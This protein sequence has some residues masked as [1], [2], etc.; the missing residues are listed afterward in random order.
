M[1]RRVIDLNG[2]DWRFG[3]APSG[4]SP[5]H[6]T[7]DELEGVA[8]WMPARV[9]GNVR[10]D[11]MRAGRLPDLSVG[12]QA[13]DSH[14]VDHHSWW[15]QRE[16]PHLAPAGGRV[17]LVLRGIDYLS[18]L[19][20]NGHHLDR[21]EG[22]FS[23]QVHEISALLRP[24]NRLAIRIVGSQWLPATR[25]SPWV[26]LLNHVEARASSLSSRFPHRRDTLKCQM[27]FGWDFAP[28]LRT[29]GI[30]DDVYAIVS[31][32]PLIAETTVRSKVA[33]GRADLAID[34]ALNAS[35]DCVVQLRCTVVGETFE[36]R[37][38]SVEQPAD[39]VV[40]TNHHTISLSL[41]QPHLWW[42]WDH[43][44]PD[45]Y[46]LILEIW[47]GDQRL[48]SLV[49]LIGLR[50]VEM[51]GW[52]LRINGRRIYARGANWVPASVLPGCVA[53]DDYQALLSSA[54][55]ANMNFLRV[56]GGGLREKQVF[57]DLCDRMGI[58]LW[59]EFPLACAFL[60]RF[61]QSEEYLHLVE[62]EA[63]A[64]V[65][66]L[67]NHPSI[68]LWCGGNEFDPARNE[69]LVRTLQGV[70]AR[71]DPARPFLPASPAQGDSH[72]WRVWHNYHPPSAYCND[73]A[74][75]A[76]EFGLQAPPSVETLR[77]FIPPEE[78][79]P[80]GPSWSYHGAELDK[81]WRYARPFLPSG[82]I[83]LEAFVS[84]GQR[85]QAYALQIAIE[86]Y[87]RGKARG[88]GGVL[89]W[90]L[91]EPWPAISWALLD[92]FR[93]TKPAYHEVRRLLAP[94]LISLHYPLK[95]YKAG[96]VLSG[97]VWVVNDVYQ[98]LGSCQVEVILWDEAGQITE[99]SV[100][101]ADVAPDSA[102]PVGH[103]HWVLSP[104]SSWRLTCALLRGDQILASN[105]Y[106]LSVHDG[107]QPTRSQRLRAWL[108]SV[109][110]PS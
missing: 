5:A 70:M 12:T 106:D 92:Y 90:Q 37:P 41:A 81:L 10:A 44:C 59:Q 18:D 84:A 31:G 62:N 49:Q 30:W 69:P 20:L 2:D 94:L 104:G 28:A 35:A 6:T 95:R 93:C 68:V 55:Q 71:E 100:Q 98:A 74:L 23:P 91:N 48:D 11:L 77:H 34:V 57:Y 67:R 47:Q 19:F 42:P 83:D 8:D 1:F 54:R 88:G 27:G 51:D 9:P 110:V 43:G 97:D 99:R 105:E 58:L 50:Q 107:V 14:W 101:L 75:F 80:P 79:W 53:E 65:R 109:V 86:H 15:F 33:T 40:G 21:H 56:W 89:V 32:D 76:S 38:V 36:A 39:L 102:G 24:Q 16:F 96:D 46:R 26:R 13:E 63:Q 103:I 45:L 17:H 60:T 72:N 82:K 25:T 73:S 61:P 85:A 52:T 64:I 87:R 66:D 29:M 108:S 4:A 78:M 22:M 3:Q 7:W